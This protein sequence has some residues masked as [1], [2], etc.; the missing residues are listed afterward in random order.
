MASDVTKEQVD[1]VL[2]LVENM[3]LK[4]EAKAKADAIAR[5]ELRQAMAQM[6]PKP[7]TAKRLRTGRYSQEEINKILS[8][9]AEGY[10]IRSVA[11]KVSRS[12]DSLLK[13]LKKFK[14]DEAD[15][16]KE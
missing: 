6:N 16:V 15:R 8:L 13:Q 3:R 9:R 11:E 5:A 1:S 14:K 2:A 10:T 7:S 4:L 12:Y